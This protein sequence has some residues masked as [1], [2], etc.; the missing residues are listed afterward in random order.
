MVGLGTFMSAPGEVGAAV[1][2]ALEAGYRHIDCA[3]VYGNEEEIGEALKESMTNLK[4]KREDVFVTSKLWCTFFRPELVRKACERSLKD[5]QLP[6][7]DLF[8]IHWPVALEPSDE[9]IPAVPRS[10]V[11]KLDNTPLLDTW[12]A[13]EKLVDE[14]LVKSIGL[15]NFNSHQIARILEICR[16]KPANL[17]VEIHANFPN[18]KL[19]EYAQSKGLTVTAYCPLGRPD[20]ASE[21]TNLLTR[22]WVNEIAKKHNKTPAQVLLRWLIQRNII[23]VPKSVTPKRIV[24]NMQ[25]FDFVL[26]PDEMKI[27]STRGLNKRQVWLPPMKPHPEYPFND[28]F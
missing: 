22:P 23:V 8:L 13:M 3:L 21:L 5:L 9:H 26:T 4:L 20:Q 19:V 16:I 1:K 12:K 10:G 18:T 27:L 24:E 14:G 15:S 17:Q 28:E 7:L 2:V 6:Y 25:L 11:C